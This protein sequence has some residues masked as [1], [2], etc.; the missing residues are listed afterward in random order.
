MQRNRKE[1]DVWVFTEVYHMFN[2]AQGAHKQGF[3]YSWGEIE[4]DK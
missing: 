1:N 4:R 3:F 2:R